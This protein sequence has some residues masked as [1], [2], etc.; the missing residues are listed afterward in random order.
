MIANEI[1]GEVELTKERA[2]IH[3]NGLNG[4]RSIFNVH[5]SEAL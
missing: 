2:A 1:C 4:K 5:F 3:G